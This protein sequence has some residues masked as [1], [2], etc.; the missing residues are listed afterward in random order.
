MKKII[1]TGGGTAGHIQPALAIAEIIKRRL[2]DTEFLYVGTP[3]GIESRIAKREGYRFEGVTVAGFSR[4]ITP[5]NVIKNAKAVALLASAD[6]KSRKII[7]DFAP[8]LVIGTGGYVSGPVVKAAADMKIPTA[9]HEQN[10]FPGLTTKL[11]SKRVD[12]IMLAFPEAA[13]R[14]G[15]TVKYTVTG[16]PTREAYGGKRI[17]RDE[18]KKKLGLSGDLCILSFGGS[19]GARTINSEAAKLIQFTRSLPVHI[20]HIHGYG[21]IGRERFLE[22]LKNAGVDPEEDKRL[23]I[24]EFIDNMPVCFAAADIV[25]SRSGASTVAELQAIG[26]AAVLIPSP[27]VTENHQ[28]FNAMV[29]GKKGAAHVIEEK[30]LDENTLTETIKELIENPDKLN[31]MAK[32]AAEEYEHATADKVFAVLENYLT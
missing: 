24:R 16:L 14:L 29:L 8:D 25:I 1:L 10:A 27:N 19:L 31:R 21:K 11:L 5:K 20:N 18:A 15:E 4:Q 12:E 3:E 32:I 26:R 28:Y 9:L 23:I 7:K 22:S 13:E 30:N 2:P 6:I 17:S